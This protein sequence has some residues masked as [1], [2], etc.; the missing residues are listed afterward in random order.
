MRVGDLVKAKQLSLIGWNSNGIV[1]LISGPKWVKVAWSDGVI[2]AEH[3]EDLET[4]STAP[5]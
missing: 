4:I 2:S 5:T 1:V 3:V